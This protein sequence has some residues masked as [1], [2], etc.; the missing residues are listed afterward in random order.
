MKTKQVRYDEAVARNL[1]KSLK[2]EKYN[3]PIDAKTDDREKMFDKVKSAMGIR[4]D[5]N[6]YNSQINTRLGIK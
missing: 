1:N 2:N 5:D 3:V 6:K 4:A